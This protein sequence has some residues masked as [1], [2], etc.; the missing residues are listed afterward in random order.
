VPHF[1]LLDQSYVQDQ[2]Q[3]YPHN[4]ER[5]IR[6]WSCTPD[7]TVCGGMERFEGVDEAVE[8]NVVAARQDCNGPSPTN[9]GINRWMPKESILS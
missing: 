6:P 1:V 2:V 3:S 5:A 8:L 7:Y 9:Q 4:V